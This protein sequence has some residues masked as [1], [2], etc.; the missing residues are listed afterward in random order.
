MKFN[1][2]LTFNGNCRSAFEFYQQVLGGEITRIGTVGESP[3]AAQMPPEL[4]DAII[5]VRWE[6]GDQVLMGSDNLSGREEKAQGFSVAIAIDT[7]AEAE[8]IFAALAAGGTIS[9]PLGE[10]FWA[11]RFGMCT[12]RFGTP[13]MVNC[14][15]SHAAS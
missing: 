13:W 4:Q 7:P 12:D 6:S 3:M 2:Y 1:T 14:E 10:T 5:H 15:H 9:M 11:A 8:R